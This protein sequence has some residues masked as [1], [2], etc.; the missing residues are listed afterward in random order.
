MISRPPPIQPHPGGAEHRAPARR[1]AFPFAPPI[2][3]HRDGA[4][5]GR[6][7]GHPA[8]QPRPDGAERQL[9][10][11]E[12]DRGNA[13]ATQPCPMARN[14]GITAM[15]T[16]SAIHSLLLSRAQIGAEHTPSGNSSSPCRSATLLL[17]RAEVARITRGT[18]RCLGRLG[19]EHLETVRC[20]SRFLW[21]AF[22]LSNRADLAR[23]TPPARRVTGVNL[24][25]PIQP[26]RMARNTPALYLVAHPAPPPIQPRPS[27]RNA[28]TTARQWSCAWRPPIQPRPNSAV[29]SGSATHS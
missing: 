1:D 6:G 14:T 8:I 28:A 5:R 13:P 3:P 18:E 26:R 27:A 12:Y 15:E 24:A 7:A 10:E 21:C 11:V 2:Q 25:A 22:L 4:E 16:E 23:N 20:V 29:R 19:A 9:R 17:S